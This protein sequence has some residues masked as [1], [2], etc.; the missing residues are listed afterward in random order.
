MLVL[1]RK[2]AAHQCTIEAPLTL[3]VGK[4][5]GGKK[6]TAQTESGQTDTAQADA[7]QAT[8]ISPRWSAQALRFCPW[9]G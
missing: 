8:T 3:H 6:G 9:L 4:A 7:A 1:A 5:R 2:N